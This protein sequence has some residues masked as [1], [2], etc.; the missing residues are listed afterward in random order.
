TLDVL[1]QYRQTKLRLELADCRPHRFR[2]FEPCVLFLLRLFLHR[3]P[4]RH[5]LSP[6]QQSTATAPLVE[7]GID[8]ETVKPRR[9]F[10][11]SAKLANRGEQLQEYLL[12]DVVSDGAV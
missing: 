9:K 11:V 12:R 6:R 10:R 3:I 4:H 7:T 5:S 1:Q 8:D 2:D